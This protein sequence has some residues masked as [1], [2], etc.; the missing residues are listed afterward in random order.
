MLPLAARATIIDLIDFTLLHLRRKGIIP[1]DLLDFLLLLFESIQRSARSTLGSLLHDVGFL[2]G[3][4]L[5]VAIG[6]IMAVDESV[7]LA[8]I[9]APITILAF[10]GFLGAALLRGIALAL[11]ILLWD[12]ATLYCFSSFEISL[13]LEGFFEPLLVSSFLLIFYL[14]TIEITEERFIT[15]HAGHHPFDQACLALI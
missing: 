11:L 1:Q 4:L 5:E 14:E 7:L 15:Y 9:S 3:C 10:L 8:M 2:G 12:T 13:F 6:F